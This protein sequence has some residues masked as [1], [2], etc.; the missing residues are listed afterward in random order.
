MYVSTVKFSD[1]DLTIK[2]LD[3]TQFALYRYQKTIGG[4]VTVDINTCD[5]A[6]GTTVDTMRYNCWV[7]P[8]IQPI[9]STL[10][11]D[12][13][14]GKTRGNTTTVMFHVLE[15]GL[16]EE[17]TPVTKEEFDTVLA[18]ATEVYD[19]KSVYYRIRKKSKNNVFEPATEKV[20]L[21]VSPTIIPSDQESGNIVGNYHVFTERDKNRILDTINNADMNHSF[22]QFNKDAP[23]RFRATFYISDTEYLHI[24]VAM[25]SNV[26]PGSPNCII[27]T[28]WTTQLS[29]NDVIKHQT[30]WDGDNS[31]WLTDILETLHED[32]DRNYKVKW[33]FEWLD[34]FAKLDVADENVWKPIL[35][36]LVEAYIDAATAMYTSAKP[37]VKVDCTGDTVLSVIDGIAVSLL[38]EGHSLATSFHIKLIPRN[39]SQVALR[40]FVY[41]P[42]YNIH[43]TIVCDKDYA[44]FIEGLYK[45]H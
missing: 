30:W 36:T 28:S 31:T 6:K 4:L 32:F 3:T 45:S 8:S 40:V 5:S 11:Y 24:S 19:A 22:V 21:T 29:E 25:M 44:D 17:V 10:S 41:G 13:E 12:T 34:A 16:A 35:N 23:E 33:F 42:D 9:R 26:P 15:S 43:R 38:K 1:T 7:D 18:E 14:N 39:D 37:D 27:K 20:T 2:F